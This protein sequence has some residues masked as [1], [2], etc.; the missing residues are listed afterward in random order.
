MKHNDTKYALAL[1]VILAVTLAG[2]ISACRHNPTPIL[3][4]RPCPSPRSTSAARAKR[5]PWPQ[6]SGPRKRRG[7]NG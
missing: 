1:L 2:A 7:R 6:W 3:I 5:V 4:A